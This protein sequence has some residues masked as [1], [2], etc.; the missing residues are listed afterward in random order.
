M[1]S[2]R[3]SSYFHS[4][5]CVCTRLNTGRHVKKHASS[6]NFIEALCSHCDLLSFQLAYSIAVRFGTTWQH[7]HKLNP[8]IVP[9]EKNLF[10][11]Q[12]LCLAPDLAAIACRH[13]HSRK[14]S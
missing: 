7:I 5:V 11:G 12:L 4:E 8:A 10:E 3:D 2:G 9:D 1:K 13:E 6:W 14:S